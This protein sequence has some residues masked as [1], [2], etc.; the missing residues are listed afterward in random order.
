MT[1]KQQGSD[2]G[3]KVPKQRQGGNREVTGWRQEG[4]VA[5]IY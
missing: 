5:Q 2:R 4:K 3:L 1:G